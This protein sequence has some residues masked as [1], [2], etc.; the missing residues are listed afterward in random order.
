VL[1]DRGADIAAP[2]VETAEWGSTSPIHIA[3][4]F[5]HVDIVWLLIERGGAIDALDNSRS[6]DKTPLHYAVS[7]GHEEVSRHLIDK[8]AVFTLQVHGVEEQ[9]CIMQP[10]MD[11]RLR[12]SYC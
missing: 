5:G 3:S 11:G 1:L 2:F 4:T 12:L 9:H 10:E 7:K 8:K 6:D